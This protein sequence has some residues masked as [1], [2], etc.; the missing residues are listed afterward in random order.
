MQMGLM[1]IAFAPERVTLG[2]ELANCVFH[3]VILTIS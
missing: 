1:P 3:G 2:P